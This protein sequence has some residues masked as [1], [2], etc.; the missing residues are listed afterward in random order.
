MGAGLD[1]CTISWRKLSPRRVWLSLSVKLQVRRRR[2]R[3][4]VPI[5]VAESAT[6]CLGTG[7]MTGEETA[8]LHWS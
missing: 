6:C 7:E 3:G 4:S 1:I 2:R 8:Y 5:P